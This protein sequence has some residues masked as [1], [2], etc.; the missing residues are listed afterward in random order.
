MFRAFIISFV[1]HL[2]VLISPI[3][4]EELASLSSAGKHS[5]LAATLHKA[6]EA[7][8]TP[9]VA[10]SAGYRQGVLVSRNSEGGRQP[11]EP[12]RTQAKSLASKSIVTDAGFSLNNA[13]DPKPVILAEAS[14]LSAE[15]EKEYR[16]NL[17]REA[18]K[19][20]RYPLLARERG[21]E[22]VVVVAVAMPLG[23][24]PPVV[25]LERSSG[26]DEL[27]HQALEMMQTAA[28]QA[29]LPVA[30]QGRR[31]G[32]SLPIEYRLAD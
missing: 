8:A 10:D 29:I 17:S 2:A 30:M 23:S 15:E 16:L 13:R 28:R 20:K 12:I 27:D 19:L 14:V 25:S 4:P 9:I 21:W 7:G 22:G 11:D 6:Y 32:I 31:F 5:V 1:L 18:R 26:Y 3:Q 24:G